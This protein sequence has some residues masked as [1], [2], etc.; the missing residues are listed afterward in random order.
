MAHVVRKSFEFYSNFLVNFKG[1]ESEHL[2]I[3]HL[4]TQL[5]DPR[6]DD[7]PLVATPLPVLLIIIVYFYFILKLGP[8]LMKNRKPFQLDSAIIS[9]NVV[10]VVANAANA[11]VV[12][13]NSSASSIMPLETQSDGFSLLVSG[14]HARSEIKLELSLATLGSDIESS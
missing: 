2:S 12:S 5:L 11:S 4:L 1:D 8:E 6:V 14:F 9:F 3:I 10:Q 7:F 13:N